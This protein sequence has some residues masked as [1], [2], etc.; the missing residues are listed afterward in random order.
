MRERLLGTA[1]ECADDV[2]VV[3]E[4][5]L[6][7]IVPIERLLAA[8]EDE[9]IA[10]VMDADPPVVSP[11]AYQEAVA[12]E[13]VRRGESSVAV[14][15][16]DGHFQGLIPPHR[17][18]AVLLAEHDED[19]ARLG[20]YLSS[21]RTARQAAR[22]PV[23]RRLWHRLPWLL[24]GL[25]GAFVAAVIVGRFE[26]QL[27]DEVLLAFFL[28][29]VVYMSSAIGTQ[30]QTVVIRGFSV[31]VTM[32]ETL[33]RELASGLLLSLAIAAA[34]LPVALVGWG[35]FKVASGVALALLASSLAATAIA[36]ALP[37][38]FQ[39]YGADPAFGSGPLATVLQDVFTIAIYFGVAAPIAT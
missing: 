39:R 2:A 13:M 21:S 11:G 18:L 38:A 3:A 19:L 25:A 12:W 35:D 16:R 31:G 20:G 33:R 26:R 24:V 17:M 14:V 7:G 22:E 8:A 37:W 9:P 10:T 28:P 1:F 32:R 23:S 6:V 30:T 34:F 15:D 36:L 4:G 27:E 5:V 29:G